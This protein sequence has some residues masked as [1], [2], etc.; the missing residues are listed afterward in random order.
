MDIVK[1]DTKYVCHLITQP[2]DY[3][4]SPEHRENEKKSHA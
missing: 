4:F 3:T 2:P 1:N